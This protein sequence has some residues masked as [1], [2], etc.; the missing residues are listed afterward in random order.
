MAPFTGTGVR[1]HDVLNI[2]FSRDRLDEI[3][4]DSAHYDKFFRKPRPH[5][6]DDEDDDEMPFLRM[7]RVT[8]QSIADWLEA[9][10]TFQR[11]G[12]FA[13][14]VH[15]V[16]SRQPSAERHGWMRGDTLARGVEQ[17]LHEGLLDAWFRDWVTAYTSALSGIEADWHARAEE[18]ELELRDRWQAERLGRPEG[19]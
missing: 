18:A 9:D 17:A 7:V 12:F 8:P 19:Q 14:P 13:D 6:P 4:K 16:S 3:Q 10:F 1:W 15:F 5:V 11:P 2:T